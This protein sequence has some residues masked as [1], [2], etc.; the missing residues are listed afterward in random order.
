MACGE[1]LE[2]EKEADKSGFSSHSSSDKTA[3]AA[4]A[5]DGRDACVFIV[6]GTD[7]TEGAV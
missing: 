4:A 5:E 6:D 1:C 3:A 7:K 2:R